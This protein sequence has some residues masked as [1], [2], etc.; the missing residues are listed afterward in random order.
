MFINKTQPEQQ[1]MNYRK[2]ESILLSDSC[3]FMLVIPLKYLMLQIKR[4]KK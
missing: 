1:R 2:I 3:S 4:S